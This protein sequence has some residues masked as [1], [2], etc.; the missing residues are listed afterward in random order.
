MLS[1]IHSATRTRQVVYKKGAR[2]SAAVRWRS[3]LSAVSTVASAAAAAAAAGAAVILYV[4]K[5]DSARIIL[6][7]TPAAAAAAAAAEA[8]VETALSHER[9]LTAALARAPF[10]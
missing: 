6:R 10:L 8:A 1:S 2:A 4:P 7:R 9:H 3:W 5:L